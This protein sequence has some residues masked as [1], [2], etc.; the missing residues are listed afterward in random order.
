MY[1]SGNYDSL[2]YAL[3]ILILRVGEMEPDWDRWDEYDED[4]EG[5][6]D[7]PENRVKYPHGFLWSCCGGEPV[8]DK[9]CETGVHEEAEEDNK[10]RG[11]L[12]PT[13]R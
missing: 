5:P 6:I 13:T 7:S 11:K 12:G 1:H 3:K 10:S 8:Y 9:G 2:P 4:I